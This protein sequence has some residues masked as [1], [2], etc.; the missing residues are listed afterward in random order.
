[1]G[2]KKMS[3]ITEPCLKVPQFD[4]LSFFYGQML[5]PYDL[6][7]EQAYFKEKLK[8]INRCLHGYG[9]LCG[10]EV[11]PD[12]DETPCESEYEKQRKKYEEELQNLKNQIAGIQNEEIIAQLR[13]KVREVEQ[14]I[15]ETIEQEKTLKAKLSEKEQIHRKLERLPKHECPE[16][17]RTK[18]KITPGIALDC[19]G[20]VIVVRCPIYIDVFSGLSR[21]EQ[22]LV[23]NS[24]QIPPIWVSICFCEQP[25]EPSRPLMQDSCS[26]TPDCVYGKLRDWFSIRI[27]LEEPVDDSRCMPCCEPCPVDC[28]LLARIDQFRP[29]EPLIEDQIDNS[30]RRILSLYNP[31]TITG[32][33]W[34]HNANYPRNRAEELLGTNDPDAGLRIHFSRPVLTETLQRGVVD[35]WVVEGG[36]G[37][38]AGIFSMEGAFVGLPDPKI[39]RTVDELI[40]RQ[41]TRESLQNG[42]RV[43]VTVRCDFILDECC[44][45]V[46]GNHVGGR[47]PLLSDCNENQ[48]ETGYREC[49][50]PPLNYM[51]W[52][53]GNRSPGGTFESWFFISDT[54]QRRQA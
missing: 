11:K 29:G 15:S 39:Q 47:V 8:L 23:A 28:L 21:R 40:Y 4:R 19:E 1:M 25:I 18:I 20:N 6:Q 37:R 5:G 9:V 32:I 48:P 43:I 10:L 22:D 42:D 46:D 12:I 31:T 53:T 44:R 16:E 33:N 35:L 41:T 30:V 54:Y 50:H 52:T 38:R 24:K 7:R 36:P 13:E 2:E 34:V 14:S 26:E 49:V 17:Y 45:P 3:G 27:S 51:P